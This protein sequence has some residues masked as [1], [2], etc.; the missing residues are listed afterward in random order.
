MALPLSVF[1]LVAF[2]GFMIIFAFVV[3]T[4]IRKISFHLPPI[5]N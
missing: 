5:P 4:P 2:T 3:G 1:L